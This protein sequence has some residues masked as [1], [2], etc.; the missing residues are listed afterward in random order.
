MIFRKL[1]KEDEVKFRKWARKYHTPFSQVNDLWHPT[2][3]D[4]CKVIDE[5][6]LSW[7]DSSAVRA[8][9]S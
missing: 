8:N 5:E 9:D 2:V 6:A 1:N 4:E 3:R 7:A